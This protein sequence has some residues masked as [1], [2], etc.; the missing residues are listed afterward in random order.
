[1]KRTLAGALVLGFVS[2]LLTSCA[3]KEKEIELK[4]SVEVLSQPEKAEVRYRGKAVGETPKLLEVSTYGDLDAIA[5]LKPDLDVVEKRIRILSSDKAQL[6]F[7]FGKGEVSPIARKLGVTRV[8][9]FEYAEKVSFDSNKADLKPEG[10]SVLN[11]QA[12]ILNQHFPN[13]TVYVCGYTD[14]TGSDAT[15]MK[16]STDRAKTV[17]DFLL[18]QGI[19]PSRMKYQGFGPANPVAPN[20]T[21]A[22][23]S[24]NRRVEVVLNQ[25][26]KA[27]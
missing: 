20:D 14:S 12:E 17:Y 24:K 7:R 6:F 22:N 23:R 8:L 27:E 21:E 11:R 10:L 26:P 9:V 18:T 1:M 19:A 13:A 25:A 2:P 16:L 15:N 3:T 5:A 4:M